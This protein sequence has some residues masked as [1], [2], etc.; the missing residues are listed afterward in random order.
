MA[1]S[2]TQLWM[3]DEDFLKA[4]ANE[5][6]KA[7]EAG[8]NIRAIIVVVAMDDTVTCMAHTHEKLTASLGMLELAKDIMKES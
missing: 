1:E 5:A 7:I 3:S 6:R 2:V 8:K 4:Q